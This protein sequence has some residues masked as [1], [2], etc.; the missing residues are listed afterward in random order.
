M[1]N[2]LFDLPIFVTIIVCWWCGISDYRTRK[3]PNVV[4]LPAIL[5]GLLMNT[6]LSLYQGMGWSGLFSSLAGFGI[7][8]GFF[9][10]F[11]WISKGTKMGA[12]DVKLFGAIGA[13]L[14]FRLTLYA[15][16]LTSLTGLMVAVILFFPVFYLLLRTANLSTLTSFRNK[17][18]PYGVSIAIGTLL[19]CVLKLCNV[20]Q[21][22]LWW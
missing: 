1:N 8:F 20:I 4:T 11:Y 19:V 9:F 13:L 21:V 22:G 18:V 2:I 5:L 6:S 17:P 16:V 3:I 15:L 14:G 10:F 7:G 12:G